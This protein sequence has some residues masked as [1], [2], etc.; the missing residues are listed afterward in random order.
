[1]AADNTDRQVAIS[2]ELKAFLLRS[3]SKAAQE[4]VANDFGAPVEPTVKSN[5]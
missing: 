3:E 1:M 4:A 5:G 2:P